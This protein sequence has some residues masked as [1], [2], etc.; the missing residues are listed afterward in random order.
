M[1]AG[2]RAWAKFRGSAK[3]FTLDF[4]HYLFV[5]LPWIPV[6]IFVKDYGFEIVR[7]RGPSMSP[8]FNERYN[9]T[10]WSD[11]CLAQK[12]WAQ[13][14]LSRGMIVTFQ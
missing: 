9:E 5:T 14:N 6:V 11:I 7:V 10:Q 12:L 4:S 1:A 2:S 13:K 8:Y 3:A